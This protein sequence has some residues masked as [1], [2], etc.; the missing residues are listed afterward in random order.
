MQ[1]TD[2]RTGSLFRRVRRLRMPVRICSN[3][4]FSPAAFIL[5]YAFRWEFRRSACRNMVIAQYWNRFSHSLYVGFAFTT[6]AILALTKVSRG[7]VAMIIGIALSVAA[8]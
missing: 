3:Y 8:A 6:L 4:A 1:V 5:T 7:E 2:L